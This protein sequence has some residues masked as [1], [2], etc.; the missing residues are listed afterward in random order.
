MVLWLRKQFSEN[1]RK[2][3]PGVARFT[4]QVQKHFK[5]RK[6]W[7]QKLIPID[8]PMDI[9]IAIIITPTKLLADSPRKIRSIPN[10][11]LFYYPQTPFH[12]TSLRDTISIENE[13]FLRNFFPT[14][15]S[16][17]SV[18]CCMLTHADERICRKDGKKSLKCH[19]FSF[20]VQKKV[21]LWLFFGTRSDNLLAIADKKTKLQA[22][23]PKTEKKQTRSFLRK[24]LSILQIDRFVVVNAVLWTLT[25]FK[26]QRSTF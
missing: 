8:D 17:G 12:R 14:S 13:K 2:K 24:S 19:F 10:F 23:S 1:C 22:S 21:F 20:V 16:F 5:N 26:V 4:L 15:C 3:T 18:E 25:K 6:N 11:L 9:Q 7:Q